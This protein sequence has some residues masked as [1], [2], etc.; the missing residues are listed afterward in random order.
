MNV[1]ARLLSGGQS[2]SPKNSDKKLA[3]SRQHDDDDAQLDKF[4]SS[5]EEDFNLP[6]NNLEGLDHD[7]KKPSAKVVL[8]SEICL[9]A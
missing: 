5:S 7:C 1:L 4:A 2:G 3:D 9:Y 8:A 6:S